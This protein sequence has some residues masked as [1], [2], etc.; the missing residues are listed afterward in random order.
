LKANNLSPDLHSSIK[1]TL[2]NM[3]Y[4]PKDIDRVLAELPEW[5]SWVSEVIPYVIK[6]LS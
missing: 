4:N 6:N 2:T 5:I 1:S 3:W